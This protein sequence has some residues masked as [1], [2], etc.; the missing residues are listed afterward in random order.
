MIKNH[1]VISDDLFD[2]YIH[3]NAFNQVD[4]LKKISK[5]DRILIL[6]FCLYLHDDNDL[7]VL[8]NIKEFHEEYKIIKEYIKTDSSDDIEMNELISTYGPDFF[9]TDN[10]KRTNGDDIRQPLTISEVRI[11]KLTHIIK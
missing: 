8:K 4:K 7:M 1:V 2:I 3:L 5:K 11:A 9:V 6:S 10:A